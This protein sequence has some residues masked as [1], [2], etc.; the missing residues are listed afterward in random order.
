MPC[1]ENMGDHNEEFDEE[2]RIRFGD[3]G[4]K[5][6]EWKAQILVGTNQKK[7]E[8]DAA[9][10]SLIEWLND[11]PQRASFFALHHAE[12]AC[13]ILPHVPQHVP[14][15]TLFTI[16]MRSGANLTHLMHP[17]LTSPV[18]S[19]IAASIK[20]ILSVAEKDSDLLLVPPLP[21]CLST[22]LAQ[23]PQQDGKRL[24]EIL[25]GSEKMWKSMGS[26]SAWSDTVWF[27]GLAGLCAQCIR[28]SGESDTLCSLVPKEV[29]PW[30]THLEREFP[31]TSCF[32]ASIDALLECLATIHLH[33]TPAVQGELIVAVR[34]L[35]SS[36]EGYLV[37]K[38][39]QERRAILTDVLGI[40]VDKE[41]MVSSDIRL[42]TQ[43]KLK[44]LV[45]KLERATLL[46]G[47]EMLTTLATLVRFLKKALNTTCEEREEPCQMPQC[48]LLLV[49]V[50][51]NIPSVLQRMV[52]KAILF[53]SSPECSVSSDEIVEMVETSR[54]LFSQVLKLFTADSLFCLG[55][56]MSVFPQAV[57][58][59]EEALDSPLLWGK[60]AAARL[61]RFFLRM[62]HEK[63]ECFRRVVLGSRCLPLLCQY[64]VG[65]CQ[66]KNP[67]E[68]L[69]EEDHR[70]TLF[71]MV[72]AL[73]NLREEEVTLCVP[74]GMLFH[75][76]TLTS[77]S[78]ADIPLMQGCLR[79]MV[80]LSAGYPFEAASVL[81]I[82]FMVE[83]FSIEDTPA[84]CN[85]EILVGSLQLMGALLV[86]VPGV[87]TFDWME[88]LVRGLELS[89]LYKDYPEFAQALWQCCERALRQVEA[90]K[91]HFASE[92]VLKLIAETIDNSRDG[93]RL[94]EII[95]VA[96]L[97]NC[98]DA[99]V[100]AAVVKL[101]R[102]VGDRCVEEKRLFHL[103]VELLYT[104]TQYF[105]SPKNSEN[106]TDEVFS[107]IQER[108]ILFLELLLALADEEGLSINQSISLHKDVVSAVGSCLLS[109]GGEC[110]GEA[111]LGFVKEAHNIQG[112]IEKEQ[113]ILLRKSYIAATLL[114]C[115]LS[116]SAEARDSNALSQNMLKA[117]SL[118]LEMQPLT[119][120]ILLQL[121]PGVSV[122]LTSES[123]LTTARYL[124]HS[125]PLRQLMKPVLSEDHLDGESIN[126]SQTCATV[127]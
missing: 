4:E 51:L 102:R 19:S 7:R 75:L 60:K 36:A 86:K 82:E 115:I 9:I 65:V 15:L 76:A 45:Q 100:E 95:T 83:Q 55:S 34:K 117:M 121:L 78:L 21:E 123:A 40:Q 73:S 97:M 48:S 69:T 33:V 77:A 98:P 30:V 43:A 11:D 84:E 1:L 10:N 62:Q 52:R 25:L 116:S 32:H 53:A 93:F 2:L 35:L 24:A 46:Q 23:V 71:L 125:P 106:K 103:S 91:E 47:D 94:T 66:S 114:T 54:K 80:V 22:L 44:D 17:P 64:L 74:E 41:L 99:G 92:R 118:L 20:R 26:S 57:A 113:H 110:A 81:D 88:I 119:T 49:T 27:T 39:K 90:A 8:D 107:T 67:A 126:A 3:T 28:L 38:E 101:G 13:A 111:V 124:V 127:F 72:E 31:L 85:A 105:T 12:L 56:P 14:S 109:Y 50:L 16:L 59:V 61:L 6:G 89:P 108:I 70:T 58:L 112:M 122:L 104:I 42:E 68:L 37:S 18:S 29:I 5:V 120:L 96:G 79:A 87:A 63:M